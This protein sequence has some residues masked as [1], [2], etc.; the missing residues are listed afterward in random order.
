M[1]QRQGN[2]DEHSHSDRR[3]GDTQQT[4]GWLWSFSN[5]T[6]QIFWGLALIK[7]QFHF[8]GVA[9]LCFVVCGPWFSFL[10][11]SS[12]SII[13]LYTWHGHPKNTPLWWA[14]IL[15]THPAPRQQEVRGHLKFQIVCPFQSRSMVLLTVQGPWKI[16]WLLVYF[17]M[18]SVF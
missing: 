8:L 14:A 3:L 18:T 2:S 10:E 1:E 11:D 16:S 6:T 12:S 7:H 4:T 9:T 17:C 13:F 15:S 5:P